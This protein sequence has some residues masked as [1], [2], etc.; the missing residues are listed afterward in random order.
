MTP[1]HGLTKQPPSYWA[2]LLT[3]L[4]PT[5]DRGNEFWCVIRK[6]ES[7]VNGREIG[8]L[9]RQCSPVVLNG[10]PQISLRH[11]FPGEESWLVILPNPPLSLMRAKGPNRTL[12]DHWS[13]HMHKVSPGIG[14]LTPI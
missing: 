12:A 14:R 5:E 1:E 6:V 2:D 8:K 11:R 4:V 3:R 7:F 10:Q 9:F 13:L